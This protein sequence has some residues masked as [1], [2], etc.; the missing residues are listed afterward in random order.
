MDIRD[1]PGAPSCD[2]VPGSMTS[3]MQKTHQTMKKVTDDIEKRFRFNTAIAAMM[4]LVNDLYKA[5]D[6][7]RNEA[8]ASVMKYSVERLLIMLSPFVP[9]IADELWGAIGRSGAL[10]DHPW[11]QYDPEWVRSGTST[12]AVQVGGRLRATIEVPEGSDQQEV[13]RKALG[14]ANVQR[15]LDGMQIKKVIY[16]PDKI[17]NFIVSPA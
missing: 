16:V 7:A 4:E 11:P 10:F 1:M 9:H 13:E 8:E 15:F 14:E 17:I 12:I 5:K 3:L 6:S 2:E